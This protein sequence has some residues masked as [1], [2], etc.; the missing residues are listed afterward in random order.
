MRSNCC[1]MLALSSASVCSFRAMVSASSRSSV[2]SFASRSSMRWVSSASWA[3]LSNR[4]WSRS[5]VVRARSVSRS[6]ICWLSFASSASRSAFSRRISAS[7]WVPCCSAR[8][9]RASRPR[10]VLSRSC[11]VCCRRSCSAW[12]SPSSSAKRWSR[13]LMVRPSSASK[14]SPR[15]VSRA[16]SPSFASRV[17]WSFCSLTSNSSVTT[18]RCFSS[19][20][21]SLRPCSSSPARRDSSS[22]ARLTSRRRRLMS[23]SLEATT[24]MR[25]FSA[26]N[27]WRSRSSTVAPCSRS[28]WMVACWASLKRRSRSSTCI[29]RPWSSTSFSW[30]R[31][32]P[33]SSSRS[34]TL[35]ISERR[36]SWASRVFSSSRRI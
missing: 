30:M 10:T 13:S 1:W 16:I 34:R 26:E 8:V 20:S 5:P 17:S 35:Q 7:A 28:F 2:A 21:Y 3:S 4:S 27:F 14:S 36:A 18:P 6:E 32:S 22:S 33:E 23:F 19:L 12:I 29:F 24:S 15:F 9:A 31:S 11:S 25:S